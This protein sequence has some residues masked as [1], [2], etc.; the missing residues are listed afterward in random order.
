MRERGTREHG[1]RN[2][3]LVRPAMCTEYEALL[4]ES[5]AALMDWKNGRAEVRRSGRKGREID[6]ELLVLQARF[7]KAYAALQ[8]H[9]RDCQVCRVISLIRSGL[10]TSSASSSYP[11]LQ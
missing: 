8:H 3:P 9:G 5:H 1:A 2:E 10:A 7:A 4:K 11:L 6:N